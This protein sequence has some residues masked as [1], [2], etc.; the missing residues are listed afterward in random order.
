VQVF[1]PAAQVQ[2]VP[3]M[4]TSDSPLDKDSVSD[5]VPLVGPPL[6]PA[7]TVTV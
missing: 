1:E 6:D 3:A 7:P 5:T 4:E 2:P